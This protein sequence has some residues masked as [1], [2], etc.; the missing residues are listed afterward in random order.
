M[1]IKILG[2]SGGIGAGLKTTSFM[3]DDDVIIDAG[4]GLGDLPLNQKNSGLRYTGV[5]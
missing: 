3:V 1:Q 2:W 5:D 4:T